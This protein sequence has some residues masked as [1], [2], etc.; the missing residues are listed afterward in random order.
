MGEKGS[1]AW[2]GF[3]VTLVF[4]SYI[5]ITYGFGFD[6]FS[7]II[8]DMKV[9]LAF[10][11]EGAGLL[12][13]A[14]RLGY[15]IGGLIAS[16]AIGHIGHGR[17]I[18][19]SAFISACCLLLM[20]VVPNSL[21]TSLLLF[22]LG[23]CAALV[24]IPMVVVIAR[25]VAERHRGKSFGMISSGQSYMVFVNGMIAPYFLL[26]YDW[27]TLWFLVGTLSIAL[28][29]ISFFYLRACGVFERR[30]PNGTDLPDPS[31]LQSETTATRRV[32][33]QVVLIW[34]VIFLS[35]LVTQPYQTYISPFLRDELGISADAAG[36]VWS[37]LGLAGISSGIVMG[38]IA[39]W[40]GIRLTLSICYLLLLS[41]CVMLVQGA[42]N[43]YFIGAGIVFG[44][45][46]YPIY[47]LIPA[48]ITQI[49]STSRS[50]FVFGIA[51]VCLGLGGMFG[52]YLGGLNRMATGTFTNNYIF[53]IGICLLLAILMAFL[54][55]AQ[56]RPIP[57][58]LSVEGD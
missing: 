21:M 37:A 41:G 23:I 7:Q 22:I 27:R 47:G 52:N 58:E 2:K 29:V 55:R 49:Y 14:T 10:D 16:F 43:L 18:V 19:L 48:Y 46:Y 33:S 31:R 50:V 57:Q 38:T 3:A 34:L 53:G 11:Y 40:I 1:L 17:M 36:L 56:E 5:G 24:Y 4:A 45:A 6:L 26:N 8:P 35:G 28:V 32:T 51:N 42:G 44:L 30:K 9:D 54:K 15:L 13:A 20:A 25:L 39:D 12:S